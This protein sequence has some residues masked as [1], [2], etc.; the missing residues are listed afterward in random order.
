MTSQRRIFVGGLSDQVT[1]EDVRG[2]FL[3]FGEVVNVQVKEKTNPATGDKS[4]FAFVDMV[5]SEANFAKCEL[6]CSLISSC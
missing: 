3:R 2:R 6:L 4:V 5:A 1:D